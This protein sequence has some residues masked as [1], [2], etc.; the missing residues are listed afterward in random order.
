MTNATTN[1]HPEVSVVICVR[2][3]ARSLSRQLDAVLAQEAV[4]HFEI[5]VVDNA[6]TDRSREIALAYSSREQRVRVIAAPVI[7]VNAARNRGIEAA[8]AGIIVL[9]DADDEV[10]PGW[11]AALI[12]ALEPATYVAGSLR[13]GGPDNAIVR[14]R[15]SVEDQVAAVP[16]WMQGGFRTASG[17]NCCF[18]KAMWASVGGFDETLSGAGDETE[19]F[20]RAGRAGFGFRGAADAVVGVGMRSMALE[21]WRHDYRFGKHQSRVIA[22][23]NRSAWSWPRAALQFFRLAVQLPKVA[24]QRRGWYAWVSALATETGM[25]VQYV[26]GISLVKNHP[27]PCSSDKH[28]KTCSR[29]P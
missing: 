8:V 26:K 2:N 4:F 21:V 28:D 15:W 3:M 18:H 29:N 19:F 17:N 14:R 20:V 25:A 10:E 1:N 22:R 27:A 12:R 6:S 11:L 23:W 9:C 5:V 16:H 7:G 24:I 13:L